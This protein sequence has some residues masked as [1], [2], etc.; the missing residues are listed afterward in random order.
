M[1]PF[2]QNLQKLGQ[3]T[4]KYIDFAQEISILKKALT[5]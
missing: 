2:A 4:D 1:L 5:K 3:K